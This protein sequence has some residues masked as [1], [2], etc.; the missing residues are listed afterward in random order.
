[1]G[2]GGGEGGEIPPGMGA[3]DCVCEDEGIELEESTT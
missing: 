3:E 1:M 2:E